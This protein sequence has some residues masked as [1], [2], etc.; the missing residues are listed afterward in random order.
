LIL[1][2]RI[3]FSELEQSGQS[4]FAIKWLSIAGK[5]DFG[6]K[7]AELAIIRLSASKSCCCFVAVFLAFWRALVRIVA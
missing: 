5:A 6:D 4:V 1:T 2:I 7:P 3:P